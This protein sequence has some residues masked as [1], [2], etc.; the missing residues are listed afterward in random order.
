MNRSGEDNNG[1]DS[2]LAAIVAVGE[3]GSSFVASARGKQISFSVGEILIQFP[4]AASAAEAR[5]A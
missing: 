1:G 5:F 4:R 2:S 3:M